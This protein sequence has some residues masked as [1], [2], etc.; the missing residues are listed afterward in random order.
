M[1]AQ[2]SPRDEVRHDAPRPINDIA[3]RRQNEQMR[4][5]LE[6]LDLES[7]PRHR[8]LTD[9]QVMGELT[10]YCPSGESPCSVEPPTALLQ[11]AAHHL[12]VVPNDADVHVLQVF[13]RQV[14]QDVLVDRVLAEGRLIFTKAETSEPS[15]DINGGG[16][17]THGS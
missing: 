8:R 3:L 13:R 17:T 7:Q 16:L 10:R 6:R 1:R 14:R 12:S 2:A 15:T 4:L 9:S 5:E 11:E